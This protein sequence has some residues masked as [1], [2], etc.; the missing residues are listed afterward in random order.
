[1]KN[2]ILEQYGCTFGKKVSVYG[3][4]AS[5]EVYPSIFLCKGSQ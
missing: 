4:Y 5:F 1:M 2:D 3:H